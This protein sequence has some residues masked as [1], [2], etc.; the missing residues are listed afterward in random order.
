[1][2]EADAEELVQTYRSRSRSP[3]F[4]YVVQLAG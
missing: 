1:V 4:A 2:S 3:E